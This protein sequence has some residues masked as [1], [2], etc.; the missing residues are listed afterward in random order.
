MKVIISKNKSLE[1]V[2]MMVVMEVIYESENYKKSTTDDYDNMNSVIGD[3]KIAL[4]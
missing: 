2:D 3:K 4:I 1:G